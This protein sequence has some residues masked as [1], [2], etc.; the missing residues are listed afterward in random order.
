MSKID[1]KKELK[2]LYLPS[3]KEVVLLDVPRMNFIM[4]DGQGDPNTSQTFKE[5]VNALYGLAYSVKFALK[6]QGIEPDYTVM[7]LEGLW[8]TAGGNML[9]ITNK[10]DWEWTL[11]IMQPDHITA[12]MIGQAKAELKAKKDPP[13]LGKVRFEAFHEGLSAQIMHIGPYVEEKPTIEKLHRFAEE[14]GYRPRGKHHELYIGDPNRNRPE[15][16]KTVLRQ[17]LE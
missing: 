9:D 13:A 5:A 10:D 11:M 3:A 17:P 2:H 1:L 8:W 6:K 7:P 4:I 12:E 16:L 14:Q 15:R